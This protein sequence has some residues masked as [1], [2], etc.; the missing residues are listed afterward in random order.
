MTSC[1]P[2]CRRS[3]STPLLSNQMSS[4]WGSGTVAS[5]SSTSERGPSKAAARG[6]GRA[7]DDPS[8]EQEAEPGAGRVEGPLDVDRAHPTACE[9]TVDSTGAPPVGPGHSPLR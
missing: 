4:L 8:R 1:P 5:L 6:G 3:V 2:N 9:G 7:R